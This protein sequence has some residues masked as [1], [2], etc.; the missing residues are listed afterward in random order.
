MPAPLLLLLL[1]AGGALVAAASNAASS[2]PHRPRPLAIVPR[3][4][5]IVPRPR[6]IVPRPFNNKTPPLGT[7]A[8]WG[9]QSEKMVVT[10]PQLATLVSAVW[11]PI[12]PLTQSGSG[13][14]RHL[15]DAGRLQ[16]HKNGDLSNP[17]Y[18]VGEDEASSYLLDK[19]WHALRWGLFPNPYDGPKTAA[20]GQCYESDV[21][22]LLPNPAEGLTHRSPVDDGQGGPVHLSSKDILDI[23]IAWEGRHSRTTRQLHDRLLG[24]I[25]EMILHPTLEEI[26]RPLFNV[27]A[28]HPMYVAKTI[29]GYNGGALEYASNF[30]EDIMTRQKWMT[31]YVK[32][33]NA[34]I[35]KHWPSLDAWE[36]AAA[37]GDAKANEM[38]AAL[39]TRMKTILLRAARMKRVSWTQGEIPTPHV[40]FWALVKTL[41]VMF[42]AAQ[43]GDVEGMKEE[44]DAYIEEE[45]RQADERKKTRLTREKAALSQKSR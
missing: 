18:A 34:R 22:I 40:D 21:E 3:P 23:A 9:D 16:R 39:L 8:S 38:M 30:T 7:P 42:V 11:W 45:K 41:I 20:C 29:R 24:R 25:K 4:R 10:L 28:A 33:Y 17:A 14:L 31:E 12:T 1:A 27:N 26:S 36:V 2:G 32:H 13:V 43:S 37:S 6:A 35:K 19:L 5:A 15:M 44:V